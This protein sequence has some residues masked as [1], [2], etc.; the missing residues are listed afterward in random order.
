MRKSLF[1][2][3]RKK[4]SIIHVE[5]EEMSPLSSY[6]GIFTT[7]SLSAPQL[8]LFHI[9]HETFN[10]TCITPDIYTYI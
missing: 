2:C 1:H 10:I 9:L 3:C 4:V 8:S 5:R 6:G 7:I